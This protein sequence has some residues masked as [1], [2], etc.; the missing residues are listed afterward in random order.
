M[1]AKLSLQSTTIRTGLVEIFLLIP[2]L[3]FQLTKV[4]HGI[5]QW[6]GICTWQWG[7]EWPRKPSWRQS[8][9]TPTH[10][11]TAS[12][13][14]RSL[15]RWKL[16][17]SGAEKKY[18]F[19]T[20]LIVSNVCGKGQSRILFWFQESYQCNDFDCPRDG[21]EVWGVE[22]DVCLDVC[23]GRGH[24]G[25]CLTTDLSTAPVLHDGPSPK[26]ITLPLCLTCLSRSV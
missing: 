7:W 25:R 12:S 8:R 2:L 11:L 10:S 19:A 6:S 1:I 21:L 3:T 14:T 13:S 26:A 16:S 24:L 18:R 4:W 22:S 23:L 5:F 17:G 9:T 20:N 15:R